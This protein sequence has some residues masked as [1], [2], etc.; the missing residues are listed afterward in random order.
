VLFTLI[1][2]N[3]RVMQCCDTI[4]FSCFVLSKHCYQH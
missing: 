3:C 4:I 2:Y 1:L